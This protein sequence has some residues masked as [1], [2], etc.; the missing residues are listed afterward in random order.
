MIDL[1]QARRRAKERL[2]AERRTDP[3]VRLTQ[4][5]HR[6]ARELGYAS[7]PALARD[8]ERFRPVDDPEVVS[9]S[10]IT[11]VSVVCLVE[12]AELRAA[13]FSCCTSAADDGRS[14]PGGE[15]PPR[16]CG[17]T[18]SCGSRWRRWGSAGRRRIRTRWTRTGATSSSGS[19]VGGTPA[20]GCRPPTC[21]G[22]PDPSADG[23]QLLGAQGDGALAALV[24]AADESRRTMSY[25]RRSADVHRTLVGPYLS[26]STPQG[27]SGFGGSDDEWRDARGVLAD[28]L[29]AGRSP[30]RFLDHACA[31]GH[32]AVSMAAG[33]PSCGVE[34]APFG[35]DIAPELVERAMAETIPLSPP[36]SSSATRS[37]GCTPRASGSTSS[38]CCSTSSPCRT[39]VE[40]LRHQLD[41]VV[42]PG[43]R[44]VLSEY[45]DPPPPAPPRPW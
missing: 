37:P 10:R 22:G 7:W 43:G 35:V 19:T 34:V 18:P 33:G 30:V 20:P 12:D 16:T 4:V 17:T 32:L 3:G 38:T 29:D 28:A 42:A 14:R 40:L 15:L 45:G 26:A 36:T 21:P 27:G 23:V 31:N 1:E 24:E 39:T 6:L 11:R 13:P 41:H 2:R 8:H 5:Q 25:E 44:L 9:W